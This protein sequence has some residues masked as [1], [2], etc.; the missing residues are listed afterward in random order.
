MTTAGVPIAQQGTQAHPWNSLQAVFWQT[1]GYTYP[2]LTTVPYV[3]AGTGRTTGPKSG[4]IQPGDEVVLMSGN[5]GVV[6]VGQYLA[7]IA[8]PYFVTIAAAPGQTPA[9]SGLNITAS[10]KFAFSGLTIE[11]WGGNGPLVWVTDQGPTMPTSD[12]VLQNMSLLS[13]TN[14][15]GWTQAAWR[16]YGRSGIRLFSNAEDTSCVSMTGSHIYNVKGGAGIFAPNSLFSNNE[17]DHFGDD[18]IDLGANNLAITNNYIHDNLNIGD[19]NHEDAIQGEGG[20]GGLHNYANILIDSNVIVRQT[21]PKLKFPVYLQGIDAFDEDWSNLTVTNNAVVTYGCWGIGFQSV[22]GGLIANNTAVADGFYGPLSGCAPAVNTTPVIELGDKTHEGAS[23]NNV[24]V[25]NNLAN[26]VIVAADP[27]IVAENNVAFAGTN[28]L[29]F[30]VNGV[31]QCYNAV[32]TYGSANQIV[33]GG[34][35]AEFVTFNPA[36]FTWDLA[37]LSAAPAVGAGILAGAPANMLSGVRPHVVDV[38]RPTSTSTTNAGA[39]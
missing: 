39:Y 15:S 30:P 38:P 34:Q 27:G 35:M 7:P 8:N 11:K 2:L 4:P 3:T 29:C 17:I 21:D 14:T 19:G 32:G 20:T 5:Y 23:S 24:T 10:S 1:T 37:L 26:Q 25:M 9:L 36:T 13:T 18:G 12:I 28:A 33:A 31:Q 16:T 6:N 22:H